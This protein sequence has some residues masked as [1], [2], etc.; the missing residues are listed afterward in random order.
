MATGG[1]QGGAPTRGRGR[2]PVSP[3]RRARLRGRLLVAGVLLLAAFLYWR[4][5]ASYSETRASVAER[6][7]DV[8][9]LRAERARL[10]RRLARATSIPALEREA[11][12]IGWVRPGERL[13]VVKG[14]PAWRQQQRARAG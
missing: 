7:A 4:P 13:F 3:R 11:R 6:K 8:A 5:L 2:K 14:I 1:K 10:E 12:R 9:A